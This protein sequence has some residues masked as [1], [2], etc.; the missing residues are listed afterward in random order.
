MPN[1][2]KTGPDGQGP[3]TGK[4]RGPCGKGMGRGLRRGCG[5]GM[6]RGLGWR[7]NAQNMAMENWPQ[8]NV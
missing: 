5:K 3:L 4:G 6:G 1:R 7:A 2:D 8:K